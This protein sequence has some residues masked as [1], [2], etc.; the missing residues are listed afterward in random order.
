MFVTLLLLLACALPVA[1]GPQDSLQDTG[2]AVVSKGAI[3]APGSPSTTPMVDRPKLQPVAQLADVDQPEVEALKQAVLWGDPHAHSGMSADGCETPDAD[4][5]AE[6]AGAPGKNMAKRAADNGLDWFALTDHV[7]FGEYVDL[8]TGESL[9]LWDGMLDLASRSR[10]EGAMLYA[11]YEWRDCSAG[12]THHRTVIFE[13]S[14]ACSSLRPPACPLA[15][16]PKTGFGL[17]GYTRREDTGTLTAGELFEFLNAASDTPGCETR[18][19]A[20]AH[21]SA[22]TRP[23]EVNW[24]RSAD[25]MDNEVLLEIFS[26]HG[27]SE[28]EDLSEEGCDFYASKEVYA[29]HGSA[30]AALQAGLLVGFVAGTDSHDANPGSTEDGP[31]PVTTLQVEDGKGV[32]EVGYQRA[33]G[34]VT[35]VLL[36]PGQDPSKQAV[37]D[38]LL[39][40]HTVASTVVLDGLELWVE[41][42][43]G[44][45]YLPGDMLP[46]GT[47]KLHLSL[48]YDPSSVLLVDQYGVG[49]SANDWFTVQLGE[50]RYLRIDLEIDGQQERLWA[51]PFFAI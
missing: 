40:R 9:P 35:A 28:C 18:W 43:M 36:P 4:C 13:S 47:Y 49:V 44:R 39:A 33:P 50:P 27:S 21:H 6:M 31:G 8:S 38:G 19:V 7:E 24:Q 11:G 12:G 41:D 25:R 48:P 42:P 23:G 17:E 15:K 46:S 26:E 14:G 20:F 2:P 16:S 34:G 45:M 5:V 51:S 30:Q 32:P 29:P 37:F 1:N 10:D 22:Y 3:R